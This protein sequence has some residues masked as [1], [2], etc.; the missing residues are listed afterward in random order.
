MNIAVLREQWLILVA[1]TSK[2]RKEFL[3]Q[4]DEVRDTDHPRTAIEEELGT[5]LRKAEKSEKDFLN[6]SFANIR[7][8]YIAGI[9]SKLQ[10]GRVKS[11][12]ASC[13]DSTYTSY[14]QRIEIYYLY[15]WRYYKGDNGYECLRKDNSTTRGCTNKTSL[16][17]AKYLSHTDMQYKDSRLEH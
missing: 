3:S 10:R 17:Y 16:Q 12:L 8:E 6:A 15:G 7:N 13:Y 11:I 1:E 2:L 5:N 9:E 14:Q 4:S